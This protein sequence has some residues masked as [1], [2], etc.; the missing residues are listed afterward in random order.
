M[1]MSSSTRDYLWKLS[2]QTYKSSSFNP[3]MNAYSDMHPGLDKPMDIS[4]NMVVVNMGELDPDK[5]E[6]KFFKIKYGSTL[7][8][9]WF[10]VHQDVETVAT[11]L[12]EEILQPPME[13]C[14]LVTIEATY[15]VFE[16]LEN[17]AFI[18][19]NT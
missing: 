14:W 17:I 19:L 4:Y 8:N 1:M 15:H 2:A 12:R 9:A 10:V 11:I 7:V 18:S 3:T 13:T 16:A 5:M 6:S